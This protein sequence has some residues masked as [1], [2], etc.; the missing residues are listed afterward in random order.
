[1]KIFE[2]WDR[3]PIYKMNIITILI[4][5]VNNDIINAEFQGGAEELGA[6]AGQLFLQ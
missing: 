1:M 2:Q 6:G 5:F 3:D 4:R